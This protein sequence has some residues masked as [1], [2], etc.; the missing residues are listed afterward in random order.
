MSLPYRSPLSLSVRFLC[1]TLPSPLHPNMAPQLTTHEQDLI[2]KV[3]AR[4]GA[5]ASDALR[6]AND[7]R[8]RRGLPELHRSS[9][10]RFIHGLT[11][12]RSKPERR[13]RPCSLTKRDLKKFETSRRK[14]IRKAKGQRYV[15]YKDIAHDAG[16]HNKS[17]LR[18]L[19][20]RVR[21][22][23][24]RFRLPRVRKRCEASA[25]RGEKVGKATRKLLV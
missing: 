4:S 2:A 15:S 11:H 12:R 9:V 19:Q 13:G 14:L 10:H 25:R 18:T 22:G 8:V 21:A 17:C 20:K 24:V 5:T 3:V 23:G 1:P 6:A 7:L 16:I